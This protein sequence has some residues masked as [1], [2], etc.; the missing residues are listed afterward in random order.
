MLR[1]LQPLR[2]PDPDVI[3]VLMS[4]HTGCGVKRICFTLEYRRHFFLFSALCFNIFMKKK[5]K[6]RGLASMSAQGEEGWVV[7]QGNRMVG[8]VQGWRAGHQ[9]VGMWVPVCDVIVSRTVS[10]HQQQQHQQPGAAL[11]NRGG[12]S[13]THGYVYFHD[14]DLIPKLFLWNI[15]TIKEKK[16]P[17]I[18]PCRVKVSDCY[19]YVEEHRQLRGF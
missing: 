17:I 9:E 15:K 4:P 13:C 7:A 6:P 3:S 5:K 12:Q 2:E 11:H 1:H 8:G 19:F 10:A 16:N 14:C 18:W